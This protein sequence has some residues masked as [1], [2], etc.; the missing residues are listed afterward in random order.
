AAFDQ[1]AATAGFRTGHAD[2]LRLDV[3]AFRIVAARDELAEPAFLHYKL[4]LAALRAGFLQKD[5]GL[6]RSL[7]SRRELARG[8]ALGIASARQELSEAPTLEGHGLSAVF[9]W[10][11]LRFGRG[12]SIF[13]GFFGDFLR[14]LL[15]I[16]ALRICGAGHEAAEL[17]PF[18]H[19][20]TA[21]L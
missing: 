5:V 10:L 3:F 1:F 12:R 21:A 8:F 16:F 7:S 15:G 6:S 18:D 13:R 9:A 14:D 11:R 4:G 19:H 17:P 2:R 20:R